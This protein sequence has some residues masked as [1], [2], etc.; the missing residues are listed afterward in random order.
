MHNDSL[1]EKKTAVYTVYCSSFFLFRTGL[2][3]LRVLDTVL[4]STVAYSF[5]FVS[6][7]LHL[8]QYLQCN[9]GFSR[10]SF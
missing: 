10:F 1:K 7:I 5:F 4:C 3:Y 2:Q 8:P 6:K 9:A